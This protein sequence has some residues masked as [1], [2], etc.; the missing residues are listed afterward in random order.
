MRKICHLLLLTVPTIAAAQTGVSV[1]GIAQHSGGKNPGAQLYVSPMLSS[2]AL[3]NDEIVTFT[4]SGRA[5]VTDNT[6]RIRLEGKSQIRRPDA[7]LKADAIEYDRSTGTVTA[8]GNARLLRDGNLITG[9][10]LRYN[11]DKVNGT[12]ESPVYNLATGAHGQAGVANIVDDNHVNLQDA[13]YSGCG[14]E[15]PFWQIRSSRV[16]L[17]N[18]ENEGIAEDGTLYIKGVPVLWSP[19]LTFPVRAEKKTGFLAPTYGMTSRSGLDITVPYFINL[20]PQYDLTLF[21]RY[22]S[23]R[24]LQLGAEFRYMQPTYSG[25]LAGTYLPNDS[26]ADRKRWMYSWR[27][28]QSLGSALGFNFQLSVDWNAV[29]DDDYYRDFTDMQTVTQADKTYLN[30][31]I[32]LGFYGNKYWDGYLQVQKYQTLQDSTSDVI[33]GQYEKVPELRI[34]GQRFDWHGFDLETTNTLTR[35][36][37]PRYFGPKLT[38]DVI[39]RTDGHLRPDG[40]RLT[41][42]STISYPITRPGW[43]I[44][45]KVGL[46]ASQYS[47]DWYTRYGQYSFQSQNGT[48]KR[49]LSRVLPIFS[50]DAGMTFERETTLFG[51]PSTQTLEPRLYYLYI[52]YQDQS[53]IPIFD[54]D[55]SQFGFASAFTENRYNGGWDRINNANQVTL[56]LTSRWFDRDTGFQRLALQVAQRIYFDTQRVTLPFESPRIGTRSDWIFGAEAALT[57]T[58]STQ[59]ALQIDPYQGKTTQSYA[60]VKWTPKRLTS[61]SLSYRYQRDPYAD[62]DRTDVKQGNPLSYQLQ[63]KETVSFAGQWPF[64]KNLYG[65]G[66][67]DYSLKESRVTQHILGVEYKGDCCWTGRVVLKRYAVS[68]EDSNS[69]IFF[70]LELAGLGSVGKDPIDLLRQNVPGYESVNTPVP[71]RTS[72]ERY[73]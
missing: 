10:G 69:A 70:Q 39:D 38:E 3:A 37:Y 59:A 56:G 9:P 60:S 15:N 51:Y 13:T 12:I 16:D 49:S 32:T 63:G 68:K 65:V 33:Y 23:K 5:D 21:P 36:E 2:P 27:H 52:P 1:P 26:E 24:G 57:N 54:T 53:D 35:F 44:T 29:S 40:T 30:R 46:H 47:T 50:L 25:T 67:V 17:Y 20:D 48:Q 42:Y 8:T 45:P 28:V 18:D 62:P 66:R 58:F 14:C 34:H 43:Y 73:E 7:I 22:L 64:T 61:L 11:V 55:V 72:F 4:D 41:S 31:N 19:Y 6:N 71:A